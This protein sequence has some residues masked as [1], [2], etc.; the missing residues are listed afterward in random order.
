[1][2]KTVV[3]D[4]GKV[5]I[6]FDWDEFA[7]SLFDEET[8]Q[9]VT[10]A[11][12]GNSYWHEL[13][14]AVL[15]EEEILEL[16]HSVEPGYKAEIDEAFARVGECVAR[17]EWAIPLIDSIKGK[18]YRVL[19]LS[20]MSEHVIASH[21]EAY[22]FTEH[23][24]GGIYS[25]EVHS[26]KPEALI[27][28]KLFEKYDLKP[29]E[30]LFIDDTP[31]NLTKAKELGM[32]TIRYTDPGQVTSDIDQALMKDANH[33]KLTVLCYGDSNTYGFDPLSQGR[34]SF[35]KRWTTLLGDKLGDDYEVIAEGL[36]G[37][38]TAYDKPDEEWKNGASSFVACLGTHKPVDY[39]VIMLGT[40]DCVARLYLSSEE[41]AKGVEM[42]VEL[43][44]EKS[45]ELQGYMPQIVVTVPPA[46]S[47][48]FKDS[49]FAW[50]LNDDSVRKS[51][52]IAPL[53]KEVAERHACLFADA[54]SCTE[55][56]RD[57]MHLT[58]KGHAQLSELLYKVISGKADE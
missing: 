30:C 37:R 55:V 5:L 11:M 53:Y 27:F 56:S 35:D 9:R 25:Y 3:F 12:F 54:S 1:M 16:F 39:L 32:K 28:E 48:D 18:G 51:R 52:E 21:P 36:N 14:R 43:T 42:L 10:H 4:I 13:D 38:T 19:Y 29:E 22:D 26:I 15:S 49:P 24:D 20:N 34:Y 2:I 6:G 17:R 44:E 45:P 47:E 41:I 46:I 8:A 33:D 7:R 31:A 58:E 23:M 57:C 50:E 40:N